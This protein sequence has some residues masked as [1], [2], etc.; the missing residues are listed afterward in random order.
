MSEKYR[1]TKANIDQTADKVYYFIKNF[2]IEHGYSPSVRDI[3]QGIGIKSTSTVHNHLTRL[4]KEGRITYSDGKRRA[5]VVPELDNSQ[6]KNVF[7]AAPL[8]G[9]VTAGTPILAT[10]NIER[11]IP[12]P[13][14]FDK[15]HE[16]YALEVKGDSM[17]DAAIMD[18]DYVFVEKSD[19]AKQGDIIVA[20]IDDE[21][22]IKELGNIDGRPFLFPKN[23]SYKPIPFHSEGCRILGIVRGVLRVAL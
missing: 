7:R 11:N 12:I 14:Y 8:I 22:T 23:S 10:Q 18:G 3:C 21:A 4:Q 16:V 17:Q 1:F 20:L 15:Y 2:F 6:E 13:D 19:S 5:I 9:K